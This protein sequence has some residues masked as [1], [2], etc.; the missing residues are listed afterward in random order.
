M[1]RK[2][3]LPMQ[4][5]PHQALHWL[6]DIHFWGYTV[7]LSVITVLQDQYFPHFGDVDTDKS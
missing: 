6:F 1:T 2:Q 4:Y 5:L 7:S 3:E